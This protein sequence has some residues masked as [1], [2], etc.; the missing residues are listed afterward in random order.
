MKNL[1]FCL[2][3]LLASCSGELKTLPNS[4]G[5]LSEIIFVVEDAF[6]EQKMKSLVNK[7]FGSPIEGLNQ[8]EANYKV[9]QINQSEFKSI[10]KTHKNIVI[11]SPNTNESS[12]QNK[13]AKDQLVFQLNW[14]NNTVSTMEQLKKIKSIFDVNEIKKIKQAI[15]KTTNK[16]AQESIKNN[17]S[18]EIVIPKEYSVIQDTTTLFWATYNPQKAEE[19]KHLII[20]SFH[21]SSV[22]LQN[23]VL[24]K[25]DSIFSKYLLGAPKGSYVKIE[26]QYPPFFKND[27]YRG[28]W[29][30]ENGFMG[31][32]FLIKTYFIEEKIVVA[33][34][35]IFAPQSQKRNYIKVLEAIL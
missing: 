33:V 10:L 2:F 24:S 19:I 27:I 15:L 17:F 13:W 16:K 8:K 22:N 25:T 23:E 31:G 4:T 29:K 1:L 3:F 30:L 34:G 12:Q 28:L 20:Y 6:W 5:S 21:P 11:I 35:V 14:Q 26:P 32:P 18:I 9:V 7:T